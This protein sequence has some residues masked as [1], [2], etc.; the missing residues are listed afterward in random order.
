MKPE[1]K[2]EFP[3]RYHVDQDLG[4]RINNEESSTRRPGEYKEL[5]ESIATL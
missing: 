1:G 5:M 4:N 3:D 2:E